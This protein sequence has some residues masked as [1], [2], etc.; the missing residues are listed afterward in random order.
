MKITMH[1]PNFCPYPGFFQ[2]FLSS[3]VFVV[4]D[5]VQMEFDITNRNKV[6]NRD[7]NWER[8]IVPI[9]KHQ[10]FLPILEVAIDNEKDWKTTI[11]NQILVY[12]NHKFFNVYGNF[13]DEIFHKNWDSLFELNFTIIKK[14]I[15]WLNCKVEIIRESELNIKNTST[16]RLVD[17]CNTL[18]AD[19]YLSGPGARN[20][21]EENLFLKNK[22]N[23]EFQE[24]SSIKYT[25][26]VSKTF[27]PN[28][29]IL[30]SLFNVGDSTRN[31]LI[32]TK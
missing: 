13:L 10:K 30:D 28:L 27:I 4:M 1:Q 29:S 21:I 14:I 17:V 11:W 7:G 32:P 24:Y 15:Q 18:G 2:K 23:L 19:T 22:I 5:D 16:H 31:L 3:D 20:Y 6:I 9:K 26:L 12:N 25:Q 8:I